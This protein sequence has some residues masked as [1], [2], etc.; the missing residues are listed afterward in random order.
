MNV[1][2][3][4]QERAISGCKNTHSACGVHT[5]RAGSR[6]EGLLLKVFCCLLVIVHLLH[7]E[8][9]LCEML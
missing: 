4:V 3:H 2:L 5:G 1:G 8:E 9:A 6:R 7:L